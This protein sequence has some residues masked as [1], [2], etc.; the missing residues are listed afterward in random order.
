VISRTDLAGQRS[1]GDASRIGR[2]EL[3][4]LCGRMQPGTKTVG[5]VRDG[6]AG[7]RHEAI[8]RVV[9]QPAFDV[10]DKD[11]GRRQSRDDAALAS[12]ADE[13]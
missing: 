4:L 3:D 7:Q 6:D 11:V 9:T 1:R 5:T 10:V 12:L 8:A 2:A 13:P